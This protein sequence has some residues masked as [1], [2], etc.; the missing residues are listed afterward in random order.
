VPAPTVIVTTV[1]ISRKGKGL[2][3]VAKVPVIAG[4]SGSLIDFNF[5]IGRTYTYQGRKVG[6]FEAKCPDGVFNISFPELLFRNEAH[7]P[8]LEPTTTLKGGVTVPC[9]PYG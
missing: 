6:Y 2:H 5:R 3:A 9:T 7:M 8:G 4:G 1:T